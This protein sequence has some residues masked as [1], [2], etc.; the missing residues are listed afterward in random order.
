MFFNREPHK[1]LS[2]LQ[3]L[4]LK[5]PPL[6]LTKNVTNQFFL[7]KGTRVP[8]NVVNTSVSDPFLST[9]DPKP[10]FQTSFFQNIVQNLGFRP[11]SSKM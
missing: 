8:E 5:G 7:I 1:E 11:L 2:S 9:C 6:D 10:R 4:A 3:N